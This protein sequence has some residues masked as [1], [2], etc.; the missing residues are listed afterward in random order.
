MTKPSDEHMTIREPGGEQI[1]RIR[2][3]AQRKAAS[4]DPNEYTSMSREFLKAAKAYCDR[5]EAR[6]DEKERSEASGS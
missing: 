4:G 1:R 2:K 3:L 5:E 6:L